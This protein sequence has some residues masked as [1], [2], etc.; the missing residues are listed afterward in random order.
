M[1]LCDMQG[2]RTLFSR[3]SIMVTPSKS[4]DYALLNAMFFILAAVN[5]YIIAR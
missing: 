5:R 3:C 4:A 1:S 2:I